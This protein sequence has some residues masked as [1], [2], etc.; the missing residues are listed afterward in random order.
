MIKWEQQTKF[1][2]PACLIV[3]ITERNKCFDGEER[4]VKCFFCVSL[5]E[6]VV[7]CQ[8]PCENFV[9]G[10]LKIEVDRVLMNFLGIR[11]LSLR[12]ISF[13]S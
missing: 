3:Y 13:M 10:Q 7:K 8:I 4:R 5:S 2:L 1:S 6:C 11:K 12:D 9:A